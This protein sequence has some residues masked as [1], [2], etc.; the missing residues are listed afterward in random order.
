MEFNAPDNTDLEIASLSLCMYQYF[1]DTEASLLDEFSLIFSVM[2][3]NG[4]L[5][6]QFDSSNSIS[7]P[8]NF[9]YSI[10]NE[11][12][13]CI[14][15]NQMYID[16]IQKYK[17]VIIK[18]FDKQQKER[19]FLS[20]EWTSN[21]NSVLEGASDSTYHP[22]WVVSFKNKQELPTPFPSSLIPIL[23]GE[24]TSQQTAGNPN[25]IPNNGGFY[26]LV[27]IGAAV[28]SFLVFF[29]LLIG[30]VMILRR[31][32]ADSERDKILRTFIDD[33]EMWQTGKHSFNSINSSNQTSSGRSLNWIENVK[34]DTGG[35]GSICNKIDM[36]IDNA[37]FPTHDQSTRSSVATPKQ[38]NSGFSN[39]RLLLTTRSQSAESAHHFNNRGGYRSSGRSDEW[40]KNRMDDERMRVTR[41]R[42]RAKN[43]ELL[44][45]HVRSRESD[46]GDL[47]SEFYPSLISS[48]PSSGEEESVQQDVEIQEN[49][50]IEEVI[51]ECNATKKDAK[52]F[53]ENNFETASGFETYPTNQSTTILFSDDGSESQPTYASRSIRSYFY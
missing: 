42:A 16:D 35:D 17:G 50:C 1:T 7:L 5:N 45:S 33:D 38:K 30:S 6:E 32:R 31:R 46:G 29:G 11:G 43:M 20:S 53:L 25:H 39:E 13:Q 22:H 9:S 2:S 44:K 19:Y 12:K 27:F 3:F 36:K 26:S 8:Q 15:I 37:V 14:D 47:Y 34:L 41:E 52:C 18:S 23:P 51:N 24:G 48:Y 4:F 49:C 28:L 21:S 10:N 40:Q